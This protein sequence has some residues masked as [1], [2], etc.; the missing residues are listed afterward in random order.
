LRELFATST[1]NTVGSFDEDIDALLDFYEG[2]MISHKQ[3]GPGSHAIKDVA[4]QRKEVFASYDISTNLEEYRLAIRFCTVD[5]ENP[6][7]LGIYS[8]YIIKAEDSNM[9]YAYWGNDV[10]NLGINIEG[11]EK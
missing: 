1:I 7:N 10:W 2:E 5:S 11:N 6:E 4:Y 3:H 9:D 8:L